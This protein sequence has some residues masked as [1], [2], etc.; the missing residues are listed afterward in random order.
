MAVACFSSSS[1]LAC[2]IALVTSTV[3][4]SG[5]PMLLFWDVCMGVCHG[6]CRL[7]M[8]SGMLACTQRCMLNHDCMCTLSRGQLGP[9][10]CRLLESVWWQQQ[11]QA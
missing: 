10:P 1:S 6:T 2:W 4:I 11:Q 7:C 5:T 8:A 9:V 3:D